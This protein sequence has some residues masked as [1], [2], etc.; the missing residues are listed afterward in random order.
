MSTGN[1]VPFDPEAITLVVQ[2]GIPHCG[3]IGIEVKDVDKTGVTMVLPYREDLVGDPRSGVLHGGAITT[4]I[5]SVSGVSVYVGLGAF[6]AIATLDLRID[7][8]RP[9]TPHIDLLARAECYKVTRQIAFVRAIAH[10]GDVND[11]VAH[12]V[13]TFMI[14]SSETKPLAAIVAEELEAERKRS[15]K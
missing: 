1:R 13:S 14:D 6:A 11:P 5:D 2:R 4:L 8:L 9:A 15:G 3:V 7:Y 10:H 12:S